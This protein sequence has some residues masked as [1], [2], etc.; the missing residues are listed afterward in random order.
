M[1]VKQQ[2]GL[3][4]NELVPAHIQ[5]LVDSA[6][7]E[8]VENSAATAVVREVTRLRT[9][10]LGG[11]AGADPARASSDLVFLQEAERLAAKRKAL[12]VAGFSNDEAMRLLVAELAGRAFQT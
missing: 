12:R 6:A 2:L 4:E 8:V 11:S 7:H 3:G 9:R 5:G 10:S 1:G